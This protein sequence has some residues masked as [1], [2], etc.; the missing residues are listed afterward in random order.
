MGMTPP[1]PARGYPRFLP[2]PGVSSLPAVTCRG[3]PGPRLLSL[4][5]PRCRLS[6]SGDAAAEAA[7]SSTLLLCAP[8]SDARRL[9]LSGAGEGEG[10]AGSDGRHGGVGSHLLR[11]AGTRGARLEERFAS[12]GGWLRAEQGG[13]REVCLTKALLAGKGGLR[14][15]SPP[16]GQRGGTAAASLTPRT[17]QVS[18]RPGFGVTLSPSTPCS[19][20]RDATSSQRLPVW[21]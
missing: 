2:S 20:G 8:R 17:H 19:D 4:G 5:H 18:Q 9:A 1:L 6:P 21:F 14:D 10:G 7:S 3:Y 13:T 12:S 15:L 16:P 11:S